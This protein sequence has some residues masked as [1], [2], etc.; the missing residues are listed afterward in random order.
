MYKISFSHHHVFRAFASHTKK[1]HSNTFGKC[2]YR[3]EWKER[4]RMKHSYNLEDVK[5][6]IAYSFEA[7]LCTAYV[8]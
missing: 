4:S 1:A 7:V 5:A 2:M 3:R 6:N 8:G